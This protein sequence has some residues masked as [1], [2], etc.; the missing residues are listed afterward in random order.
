MEKSVEI[1]AILLIG[2]I[3]IVAVAILLH[4]KSKPD[5]MPSGNLEKACLEL[6]KRGCNENEVNIDGKSF[7]EVCRE[8]G[9]D[10]EECTKH[11][12]CE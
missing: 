5:V 3:I 1:V 8:N 2:V 4:S 6:I 12:G 11:C 9:L 10:V 7:E